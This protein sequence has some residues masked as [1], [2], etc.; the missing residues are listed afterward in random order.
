MLA[1]SRRSISNFAVDATL[2]CPVGR[3]GHPRPDGDIVLGFALRQAARTKR[4]ATYP[5]FLASECSRLVVF[6]LEVGGRWD[7]GSLGLLART[8]P[9]KGVRAARLVARILRP[10]LP[11]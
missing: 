2:V 7:F 8:C 5:E 10:R 4:E 9:R 6:G 11:S 3:D 1:I